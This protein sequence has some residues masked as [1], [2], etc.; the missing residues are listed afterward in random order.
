VEQ[1]AKSLVQYDVYVLKYYKK[2]SSALAE[3]HA[4]EAWRVE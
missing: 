2:D 3:K 1:L 4:P